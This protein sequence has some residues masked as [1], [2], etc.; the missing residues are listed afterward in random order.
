MKLPIICNEPHHP[1]AMPP[2]VVLCSIHS[3]SDSVDMC[4]QHFSTSAI[5][6]WWMTRGECTKAVD[7]TIKG[8]I[9]LDTMPTASVCGALN[10]NS[11][12]CN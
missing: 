11:K 3:D 1:H 8:H 7:G 6:G 5:T 12:H 10:Y 2:E 4:L 9:L